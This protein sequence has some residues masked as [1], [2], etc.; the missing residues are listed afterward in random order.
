MQVLFEQKQTQSVVTT[1]RTQNIMYKMFYIVCCG[2][3]V[4]CALK[5]LGTV[6]NY[7]GAMQT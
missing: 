2:M 6:S 5:I 4:I 3:S 1:N 7:L